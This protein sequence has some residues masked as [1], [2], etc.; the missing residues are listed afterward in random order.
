[1][2][3]FG[4]RNHTRPRLRRRLSWSLLAALL[5]LT[6]AGSAFAQS[7]G[8]G[9]A[10]PP[11]YERILEERLLILPED[12]TDLPS[13]WDWRN[14]EGTT[15]VKDQGSCGSCWAF[16]AVAEMESKI[17]I[18]Y[19]TVL[20][21]SEQQIVSCNPYGAGCNGGWAAAAYYV[22]M[23]HGGIME[24]CMPYEGSDDVLCTQSDY[25]KFTNISTWNH[26][27]NNITQIKN[28]VYNNGPVCTAVDANDAWEGYSGGVITAPGS[29]TNHLVLIVG[30]DDRL[31]DDGA[32]IVKNSWGA[33]WGQNGYCYVAYGACNIGSGVTS[34]TFEAPPV[35]IGVSEPV[36]DQTYYGGET[37][38]VQWFTQNEPV[39]HVDLY[40]GT[41]GNCQDQ[42][43]ATEVPNT[44]TFDWV[45][46]NQTTQR[47]TLLVFPSEGT[48]RGY[49]FSLGEFH[50]LG[51]QTRYVSTAGSNT[52]P[53]DTPAKAAHTIAAAVLAGA[54]RDSVLVAAG[55]YLESGIAVN[56]Q[57][58]V[59]GG[60][61]PDFSVC[62]PDLYPTRLRG[63]NGA[64][65]FAGGA[66]D[67]CGVSNITFYDSQG[68]IGSTPVQGRHGAAIVSFGVS[69]VIDNCRFENNRANP[70]SGTGWGGAILAHGGSPL[71][72]GCTFTGN[73]GSHG[74]AVA[75][76]QCADARIENSTFL[77]NATSDSTSSF[78][79]G[80][81][82]VHGGTATVLASELRGGGAGL[83]GALAVAGGAAVQAEDLM[84][85][86]NR[87]RHG[88]GAVH[89][90]GSGLVLV[91]SQ[92]A[93][94]ISAAGQ[95][96][97]LF[98]SG[99]QLE[100]SNV[101]V[102]ENQT[103]GMGGAL[104]AENLTGGALR[105]NVFHGNSGLFVGGLY[106]AAPAAVTV[107]NNVASASPVGGGFFFNGA[108]VAADYNLAYGNQGDDF[109]VAPGAHDL[110]ADPRFVAPA[111]GDFA[112]GLHSPLIDSGDPAAD[113]DWDGSAPDRGLHGGPLAEAAGPAA[114][115]DLEGVLV[116]EEVHLTWSQVAGA[117][118]YVVY[119]DSAAVFVPAAELVC[120]SLDASVHSF[121]E[122]PPEGDWYYLVA[123]LD[124]DGR[125]GGFSDA[126]MVSGGHQTSVDDGLLP[127]ALAIAS[128]APNPFNPS[129]TVV[130]DL[131]RAGT[132]SLQV[133]DLRGRLVSTLHEGELPAGR[134]T[135]V[136]RGDGQGG[137]PAATGIYFVRLHD[138]QH[139]RT[140]KAVLAK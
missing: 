85:A 36:G 16:A 70:G 12:K 134:H 38:P 89:S 30:W 90:T 129:T 72:R 67:H 103:A 136:W 106:L 120:A 17:K 51:R 42:L 74:A 122:T 7:Y 93:G 113:S 62:D 110:V 130:F 125:A 78:L 48:D 69:P 82:Y 86:L 121:Q 27:S 55:D 116:G 91:R 133:F 2:D 128:V 115:A 102:V 21:L 105:N 32:W 40:F 56:T 127:Q 73:V 5:L 117:A 99:G 41:N 58:Y 126:F 15:P 33:G 54:G 11:D 49:G 108:S 53:Y 71:I 19:Q 114:V 23:H 43:I 45:V 83:G 39:S 98:V 1:M 61:S 4:A 88:G 22:H 97:G 28:A 26:I 13:N 20:D 118:T 81:I 112:P 79:G 135:V 31:G 3:L 94:N 44:G 66:I 137:R 65:R 100:L 92:V 46:P 107:V 109:L 111:T 96:G 101:L 37:I 123:A 57:C 132:A 87:S 77:A 63:I 47:G 59:V 34:L 131:P 6:V 9:Y 10:P 25:L 14:H 124:D 18:Y 64:M 104:F 140:A 35:R 60:W 24:R 75:L 50:I 52:P 29:G 84:I 8:R 138:G 139:S 76:S 95:G 80:A 119:R 68:S